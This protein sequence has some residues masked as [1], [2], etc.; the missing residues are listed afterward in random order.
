MRRF[1]FT[2]ILLVFGANLFAESEGESAPEIAFEPK[3]FMLDLPME[4]SLF[5]Y[6]GAGWAFRFYMSHKNSDEEWDGKLYDKSDINIFDRW[7]AQPYRKTIDDLGTISCALAAAVPIASVVASN[8]YLTMLVMYAETMLVASGTY[9]AIKTVVTRNRPYMYFDGG[10]Q[11]DMDDGDYK[12][13]FPSGHTTNAF[14][15]A[16]FA[17]LTFSVYNPESP[18]R[19]PVWIASLSLAGATGALRIASGNHFISDVLVGALIGSATG[20]LVPYLHFSHYDPGIEISALP[21]GIAAKI[22]Y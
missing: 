6:G 13:S 7:A 17:S 10:K 5:A 16:V 14:A 21:G 11:S 12:N 18:Y 3:P 1:L 4:I 9:S 19:L 8:D 15:A 2:V 20:Y 22:K